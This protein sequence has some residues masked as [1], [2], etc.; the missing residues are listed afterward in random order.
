M[1]MRGNLLNGITSRQRRVTNDDA[2]NPQ[3]TLTGGLLCTSAGSA[4]VPGGASSYPRAAPLAVSRMT[5]RDGIVWAANR[6]LQPSAAG[7]IISRRG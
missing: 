6:R 5:S 7:A 1:R 4:S 3:T 2:A